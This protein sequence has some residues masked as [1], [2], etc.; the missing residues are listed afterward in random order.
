M[1]E[2]KSLEKWF[3]GMMAGGTAIMCIIIVLVSMVMYMRSV[4]RIYKTEMTERA[5]EA[6]SNAGSERIMQLCR[7]ALESDDDLGPDVDEVQAALKWVC[8]NSKVKTMTLYAFDGNTLRAKPIVLSSPDAVDSV[9]EISFNKTKLDAFLATEAFLQYVKSKKYGLMAFAYIGIRD[10]DGRMIGLLKAGMTTAE[11]LNA[12]IRFALLYAP[13]C[14]LLVITFALIAQKALKKRIIIPLS[15]LN[16]AA[17][18]YGEHR[19]DDEDEREDFFAYPEGMRDDEIGR[20]WKTCASMETSL[21]TSIKDLKK[22]TAEKEKQAAEVA[23]AAQIQE[24]M[25]PR[26]DVAFNNSGR[27]TLK[28]SMTPAK[29]VGGDFYDYFMT[30]DDHLALVIGD[31]SGKGIPASLFMMMAIT[32]IRARAA[33]KSSPSEILREVNNGICASNP[34]MMFVTVWLGIV[35]LSTG[36]MRECNAGH[37]NTA[38]CR[39][40]SGYV[41]DE[42]EHDMPIGI[43][44]NIEFTEKRTVL[45]HGERIFVYSDGLP[46]AANVSEEQYGTDRILEVLNVDPKASDEAIVETVKKSVDAFVAEAPQFDDLTMLS[47]TYL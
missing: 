18:A 29:G 2:R 17:S 21:R 37:E 5:M 19:I 44:E 22:I 16:T 14:V 35:E 38:F 40:E 7:A 6:I 4:R 47:F 1:K 42:S 9:E 25:L 8:D 23:V 11:T 43:M 15:Q 39:S 27:F 13:V 32:H 24:G 46:E 41:M 26:D 45:K 20:L 34:E 28:G 12:R 31:V 3:F 30:D 36:I 10:E 33:G